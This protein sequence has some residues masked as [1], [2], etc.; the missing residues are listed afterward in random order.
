MVAKILDYDYFVVE[1]SNVVVVY[2]D[3]D[4]DVVVDVVVYVLVLLANI[5][6]RGWIQQQTFIDQCR[7]K[8][9]IVVA[10][11]ANNH[12]HYYHVHQNHYHANVYVQVLLSKG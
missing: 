9:R 2:D 4:D 10:V 8:Y 5:G 7:G 3:N 11:V 12:D 1:A 6:S